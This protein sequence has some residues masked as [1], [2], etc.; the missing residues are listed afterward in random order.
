[1]QSTLREVRAGPQARNGSR[2]WGVGGSRE[3]AAAYWLALHSLLSLLSS[4]TQSPLFRGS[5]THR[6][7]GHSRTIFN[8]ESA[9]LGGW[10]E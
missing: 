8:Q 10:T 2:G 6:R 4:G 9:L 3:M 1:M 7:M 5:T